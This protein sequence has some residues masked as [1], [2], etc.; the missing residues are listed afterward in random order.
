MKKFAGCLMLILGSFAVLAIAIGIS[1]WQVQRREKHQAEATATAAEFARFTG[2]KTPPADA[3]DDSKAR[4]RKGH[5]FLIHADSGTVDE[6]FYTLPVELRAANAGDV[7]T[8]VWLR[9]DSQVIG[10]YENGGTA[11]K[12][13]CDVV[14]YD[15]ARNAIVAREHMEGEEPPSRIT[16]PQGSHQ[17]WEKLPTDKV[18]KFLQDLPAR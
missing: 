8:E 18:L 2:A 14:V 13:N 17:G 11:F 9:W 10:K 4:Y 16:Y 6:M 3:I 12:T 1:A 5:L 7:G 15:V